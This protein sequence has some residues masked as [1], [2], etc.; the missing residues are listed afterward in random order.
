MG[1]RRKAREQA[2]QVLYFIDL[3]EKKAEEALDLFRTNFE[4]HEEDF[5]FVSELVHGVANNKDAIDLLI[6]NHSSNWKISRMPGIDRN[7]LRLA[8]YEL[9]FC[10]ETPGEVI[11]D[12]AVELGKKFGG[13]NSG[14]FI[15]GILDRIFHMVRKGVS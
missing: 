8:S 15:N 1:N 6:T 12:E 11:L 7:V 5:P 3:A 9:K 14:A 10:E 4:S 2:L 13:S